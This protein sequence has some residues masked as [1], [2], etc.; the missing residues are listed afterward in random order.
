M[1]FYKLTM[2]PARNMEEDFILTILAHELGHEVYQKHLSPRMKNTLIEEIR[3]TKF[4]TVYTQAVRENMM[5]GK[6]SKEK[7]EEELIAEYLA[8]AVIKVIHTE[9]SGNENLSAAKSMGTNYP[10]ELLE[11]MKSFKYGQYKHNGIWY[12][13]S[14]DNLEKSKLGV[15]HDFSRYI[16][17]KLNKAGYQCQ[18]VYVTDSAVSITHSFVTYVKDKD[19][20]WI[21]AAWSKHFSIHKLQNGYMDVVKI[22][23]KSENLDMKNVAVNEHVAV[24]RMGNKDLTWD[25]YLD[26]VTEPFKQ[27]SSGHESFFV[28][29]PSPAEAK[30]FIRF[31]SESINRLK[32]KYPQL[33]VVLHQDK[34]KQ[35]ENFYKTDTKHGF[36]VASIT[37]RGLDRKK[38]YQYHKQANLFV[39]ELATICSKYKKLGIE[40]HVYTYL[41][42]D[43]DGDDYAYNMSISAVKTVYAIRT[44]TP[45]QIGLTLTTAEELRNRRTAVSTLI[46]VIKQVASR[47]PNLKDRILAGPESDTYDVSAFYSGYSSSAYVGD[48]DTSWDYDGEYNESAYNKFIGEFERFAKEVVDTFAETIG[49]LNFVAT[50][51]WDDDYLAIVLESNTKVGKENLQSESLAQIQKDI[52]HQY[53]HITQSSYVGY[54]DL[55]S[56]KRL[57]RNAANNVYRILQNVRSTVWNGF[58]DL[59]RS[60]L[61]SY[62]DHNKFTVSHI[63]DTN[64]AILVNT[65]VYIPFKMSSTYYQAVTAV[66]NTLLLLDMENRINTEL[67]M[68]K[69]IVSQLMAKSTEL[70]LGTNTISS[71][72]LEKL[73]TSFTKQDACFRSPSRVTK[74]RFHQVYRRPSSFKDTYTKLSKIT[75]YEYGV[76]KVYKCLE[77]IYKQYDIM[78]NFLEKENPDIDKNSLARVHQHTYTIAKLF[79][80]Y[81]T[82]M[83][84]VL[85]LEHNFVLTLE[86]IKKTHNL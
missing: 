63:L 43:E 11:H 53:Q 41:L 22:W 20:Y 17:D 16:Y 55:N 34:P 85:R 10:E 37:Y 4:S 19:T 59:K 1:R 33:K 74:K 75:Q 49:Q 35:L 18:L 26:I 27:E 62:V 80:M 76:A 8:A 70:S 51:D 28:G 39:N 6:I 65:D 38:I 72:E 64:Y 7:Y 30:E 40:P 86:E 48:C 25:E 52:I 45:K 42:D 9:D 13:Q 50:I 46:K 84:N 81:G 69:A 82:T 21:E 23:S 24:S 14:P 47:Y 15:C 68:A 36:T 2:E 29:V 71:Y 32:N 12:I 54:E 77:N 56:I 44:Y 5:K 66:E 3:R 79:D 67:N 60:E 83:M 61:Q 31:L 58:K 78:V 73:Q 57:F